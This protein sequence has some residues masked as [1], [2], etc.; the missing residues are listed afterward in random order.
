MLPL[1]VNLSTVLSYLS[2]FLVFAIIRR[3]VQFQQASGFWEVYFYAAMLLIILP[4]LISVRLYR[5]HC[6]LIREAS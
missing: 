4:H 6:Q 5:K 1:W 3:L 2:G